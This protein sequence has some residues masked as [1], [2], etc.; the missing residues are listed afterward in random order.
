MVNTAK[1]ETAQAEKL[2][3]EANGKIDVLQAEVQA[4][5]E[6]VV[7]ATP[8]SSTPNKHLH[9]YNGTQKAQKSNHVRQSSWNQQS[10]TKLNLNN[11]EEHNT[12]ASLTASPSTQHFSNN[13]NI[14]TENGSKAEKNHLSISHST[15]SFLKQN[16]KSHKRI[17]S[18]VQTKSF[19]DKLFSSSNQNQQ[20][21]KLFLEQEKHIKNNSTYCSQNSL[22]QV[23]EAE[24]N[25]L[26]TL[27]DNSNKLFTK[28]CF[29]INQ[30]YFKEI[31][32]WRAH[33]D[34]KSTSCSFMKRVY[35]EDIVP[36]LSFNEQSVNNFII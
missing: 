24:V 22:D 13:Q 3:K 30:I 11:Y 34:L 18:D 2:L 33:P 32:E 10:F 29:K 21:Q 28:L 7:T 20:Q 31:S 26:V 4:L 23:D 35:N 9:S 16:T 12:L 6:L 5:K 8:T 25:F 15:Q 17:S 14:F 36:C 19:I 27:F 1:A